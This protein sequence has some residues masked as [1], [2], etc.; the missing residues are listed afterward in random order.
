M[1]R[2][3][4]EILHFVQNEKLFVEAEPPYSEAEPRNEEQARPPLFDRRPSINSEIIPKFVQTSKT[5]I[6]FDVVGRGRRTA[7]ESAAYGDAALQ[8]GGGARPTKNHLQNP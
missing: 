8:S 7:P 3:K 4:I 6:H 1:L 2:F 5:G